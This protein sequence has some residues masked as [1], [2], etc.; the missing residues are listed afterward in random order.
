MGDVQILLD[1]VEDAL[2]KVQA[3]IL[4]RA[5]DCERVCNAH[6]EL[7]LVA[8]KWHEAVSVA[9]VK[10]TEEYGEVKCG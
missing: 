6:S 9:R 7:E 5:K 1:E 4:V 2:Q 10:F 8:I 3:E